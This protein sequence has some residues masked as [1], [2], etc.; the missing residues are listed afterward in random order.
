MDL[1]LFSFFFLDLLEF[2]YQLFIQ[3]F[4][5][6]AFKTWLKYARERKKRNWEDFEMSLNIYYLHHWIDIGYMPL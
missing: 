5:A 2:Y 6:M 3:L 4:K 1:N